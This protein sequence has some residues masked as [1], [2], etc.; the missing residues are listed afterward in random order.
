ML[1]ADPG[2]YV[3]D[4]AA[5][6][7][8]RTLLGEDAWTAASWPAPAGRWVEATPTSHVRAAYATLRDSA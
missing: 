7:A 8:A 2:E 6:Q 1:V 4:G 3:A 5:R